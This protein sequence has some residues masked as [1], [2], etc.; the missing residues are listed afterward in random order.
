M[1]I[2]G[3]TPEQ[4]AESWYGVDEIHHA[5]QRPWLSG[6]DKIPK[7]VGSREFAVWL[8]TQYRLAM[9]KGIR[10]GMEAAAGTQERMADELADLRRQLADTQAQASYQVAARWRDRCEAAER[11]LAEQAAVLQKARQLA[12]DTLHDAERER[13]EMRRIEAIDLDEPTAAAGT[14]DEVTEEENQP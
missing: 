8:T 10:L 13:E 6:S 14:Q 12:L 7:D 2:G 9:A 5:I 4:F 11:K 3:K 1:L